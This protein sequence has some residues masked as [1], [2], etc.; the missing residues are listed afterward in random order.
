MRRHVGFSG[1]PESDARGSSSLEG[2]SCCSRSFNG[3]DAAADLITSVP[4][5][6]PRLRERH[7]G[8][9]A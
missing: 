3:I 9:A 2:V 6:F 7:I 5:R 4:R 1:S 8:K